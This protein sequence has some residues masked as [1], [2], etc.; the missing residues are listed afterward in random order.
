MKF[1]RKRYDEFFY[2]TEI[3][4]LPQSRIRQT[5]AESTRLDGQLIKWVSGNPN[6]NSQKISAYTNK[7]NVFRLKDR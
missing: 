6:K 1:S 3:L 5:I 4:K 2:E 7:K